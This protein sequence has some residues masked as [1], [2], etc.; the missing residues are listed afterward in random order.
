MLQYSIIMGGDQNS[1]KPPFKNSN[2]YLI[3]GPLNGRLNG[4][5]QVG[6]NVF[7]FNRWI[8]LYSAILKIINPFEVMSRY[9]DPQQQVG[10]NYSYLFNLIKHL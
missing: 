3:W 8:N 2:L 5:V 6:R 9:R 1:S 7:D 10:G 4:A